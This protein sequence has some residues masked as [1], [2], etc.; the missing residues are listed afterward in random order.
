[1]EVYQHVLKKVMD[2][3]KE[4]EIESFSKWMTYRGYENFTDLCVD[5]YYILD[6]IRDYSDYREHGS[7]STLK[8]GTMNITCF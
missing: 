8:F 7:K 4:H 3:Q 2:I 1:M 6:H 5:F